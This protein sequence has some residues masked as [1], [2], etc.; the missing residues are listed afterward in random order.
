[1]PDITIPGLPDGNTTDAADAEFPG[2]NGLATRRFTSEEIVASTLSGATPAPI[3]T[4]APGVSTAP[5]RGDHVHA[6]GAQAGGALHA[7]VVAGGA[8]GFMTGAQATKL[9]GIETGA[10][11]TDA[12]NVEA[13][14]AVMESDFSTTHAILVRQGGSSPAALAIPLSSF[15]GRISAGDVI[16]MSAAQAKAVLAYAGSEVSYDNTA[17]GLAASTVQAAIDEI[18]SAPGGSVTVSYI[19]TPTISDHYQAAAGNG[20]G[21]ANFLVAVWARDF[22]PT[23]IDAT[24]ARYHIASGGKWEIF[25]NFGVLAF[26]FTDGTSTNTINIG[27]SNIFTSVSYMLERDALFMLRVTGGA[28]TATIQGIVNGGILVSQAAANAGVGAGTDGLQLGG[29]GPFGA[30]HRGGIQ[31]AAYL[32][33]TVTNAQLRDFAE[34]CRVAGGI[35]PG[36]IAWDSLYDHSTPPG[37]TWVDTIGSADLT[38]S[39]TPGAATRQLRTS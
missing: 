3:G 14:G 24:P 2:S 11:V 32:D 33:G 37:A 28:G 16:A 7:D 19:T 9:A 38:R 36:G 10:D 6:H 18:A 39:G 34:A 1:M 29:Q 4:A 20:D 21:S 26:A 12:A 15:V 31:G 5:A 22:G 23:Q 17:S 8:S 30:A 27:V 13:A 35:V 25:W